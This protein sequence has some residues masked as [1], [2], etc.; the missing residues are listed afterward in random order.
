M[1]MQ[2][3]RAG[4]GGGVLF[5]AGEAAGYRVPKNKAEVSQPE[6]PE[7]KPVMYTQ[8]TNISLQGMLLLL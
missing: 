7:R 6:A 4:M 2:R 1:S 3:F 8:V 5:S